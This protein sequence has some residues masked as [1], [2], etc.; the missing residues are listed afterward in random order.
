MNKKVLVT[1]AN[2]YLGKHVVELLLKKGCHVLASDIRFTEVNEQ[3]EKVEYPI[4]SGEKDIFDRVG[5][6]DICIHLAWRDGFV[7]NAP[8]HMQDLSAHYTFLRDMMAG[9]LKH[10]A[11]MGSMHEIGYWEGAVDEH[12]PTNPLSLYGVAKDSLRRALLF[13]GQEFPE[14]VVQWLRGYYIT[15]DDSL[16]HSIFS[17]II[18]FEKEGKKTFPFTS[19]KNQYDFI[20]IHEMVEDIVLA[21]MQ[22][23]VTG[24]I[25]CCS[26]KPMSLGDRVEQFIRENHFA[27][28][29]EYNAFP[30]RPYDSPGI[31][32][33]AVKINKIREMA[34]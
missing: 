33:D 7:H 28:R 25:N 21:A 31:W 1:G 26:G 5:R 11:V 3:A 16:N 14:T 19:G 34:D 22:T 9:G 18:E 12:T 8:S 15:G 10:I 32:G 23:E 17:K 24:I 30:D 4:F 13:L 20:D 6:P 29:P 2:G 27:I